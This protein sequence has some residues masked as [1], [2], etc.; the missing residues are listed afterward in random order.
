LTVDRRAEIPQ[1]RNRQRRGCDDGKLGRFR[2]G[3]PLR[4]QSTRAVS[5]IYYEMQ[6]SGMAHR[7]HHHDALPDQRMMWVANQSV[8]LLF[9][10]SM[11][12]D[13]RVRARP[14]CPARLD[15]EPAVTTDPCCISACLGCLK[16]SAWHVATDATAAC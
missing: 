5:R 9:L 2:V 16:L 1:C 7:A 14:G 15:T 13:R 3:H 8:E 6:H 10:D 11:S 12:S 4:Q